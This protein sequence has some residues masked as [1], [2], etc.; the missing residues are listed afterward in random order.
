MPVELP[1]GWFDAWW[2]WMVAGLVLAIL[3]VVAPAFVF[4]G[5]A[6]GAVL[7]GALIWLGGGPA[8][9]MAGSMVNHLLLFAVLSLVAWLGLRWVFGAG[10]SQVKVWQKDINDN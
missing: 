6:I 4:L 7:T 9:W 3:E 1:M 2:I 10:K 5:F 8:G